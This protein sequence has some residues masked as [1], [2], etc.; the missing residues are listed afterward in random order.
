MTVDGITYIP[1]EEMDK[2]LKLKRNSPVAQLDARTSADS[3]G[4]RA[5]PPVEVRPAQVCVA[6]TCIA[7]AVYS[8]VA[9]CSH[10]TLVV[11]AFDVSVCTPSCCRLC[12]C[13]NRRICH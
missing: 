5:A 9:S 2:A 13:I 4:A 11:S 6:H 1:T 12:V 3:R 7:P 10:S 8:Q